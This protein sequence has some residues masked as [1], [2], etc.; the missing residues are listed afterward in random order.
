MTLSCEAQFRNQTAKLTKYPINC[1]SESFS[2]EF[3][4]SEC[5]S[6]DSELKSMSWEEE[7]ESSES[8]LML[9]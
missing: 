5:G 4:A 2:S 7:L 3:K 6:E 8:D 1:Y 9:R